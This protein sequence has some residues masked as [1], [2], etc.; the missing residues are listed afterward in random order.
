M[1][2]LKD[3]IMNLLNVINDL[4]LSVGGDTSVLTAPLGGFMGSVYNYAIIIMHSVIMPIAYTVLALFFML[5]R[6]R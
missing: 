3:A 2:N 6:N 5:E 1:S 4:I